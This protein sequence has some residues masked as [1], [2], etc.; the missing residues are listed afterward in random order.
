MEELQVRVLIP[1]QPPPTMTTRWPGLPMLATLSLERKS[2]LR[3]C[4]GFRGRCELAGE[5]F[6]LPAVEGLVLATA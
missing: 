4:S 5:D 1:A 3:C 6:A 2:C